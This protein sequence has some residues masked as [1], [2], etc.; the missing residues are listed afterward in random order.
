M[1]KTLFRNTT[2]GFVGAIQ[3]D[4]RGDR[5]AVAV[6]PGEEIALSV[7]EEQETANGP[8]DPR[9]NP[10]LESSTDVRDSETGMVLEEGTKPQLERVTEARAI[11]SGRPIGSRG[12]DETAAPPAPAGDPPEGSYAPGEEVGDPAAAEA[13]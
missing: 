13:A 3:I 11:G 5:K 4:G 2:E 6:G 9:D 12:P 7:E 8:R 1:E 10:F